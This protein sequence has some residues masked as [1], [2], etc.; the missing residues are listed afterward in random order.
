MWL[1]IRAL[2]RNGLVKAGMIHEQILDR[3]RTLPCVHLN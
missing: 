1:D 2:E 3:Y